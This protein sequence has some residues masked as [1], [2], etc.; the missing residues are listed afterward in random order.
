MRRIRITSHGC[1]AMDTYAEFLYL[2][3]MAL[4]ACCQSSGCLG[5]DFMHIAMAGL[6]GCLAE[7]RMSTVGELRGFVRMAS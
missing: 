5:D 3:V 4:S 2:T 1:R 6:A 7:T